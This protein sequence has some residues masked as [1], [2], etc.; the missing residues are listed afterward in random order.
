LRAEILA[1]DDADFARPSARDEAAAG[2]AALDNDG[3]DLA[4]RPKAARCSGVGLPG[5]MPAEPILRAPPTTGDGPAQFFCVASRLGAASPYMI[6]PKLKIVLRG[7]V[8]GI[9]WMTEPE[10]EVV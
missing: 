8:S 10:W 1:G 4:A 9:Y 3:P 5:A 6:S 2:A 7:V